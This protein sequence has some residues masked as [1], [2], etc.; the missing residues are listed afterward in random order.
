MRILVHNWKFLS[1]NL[2]RFSAIL[3]GLYMMYI[4]SD[5]IWNAPRIGRAETWNTVLDQV[6]NSTQTLNIKH[7]TDQRIWRRRDGPFS[8]SWIQTQ[9]SLGSADFTE[10]YTARTGPGMLLSPCSIDSYRLCTYSDKLHNVWHGLRDDE[11]VDF[12]DSKLKQSCVLIY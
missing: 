4:L 11:P 2:T 6:S 1:N 3:S 5:R 8:W 7:G 9:A 12:T 10:F